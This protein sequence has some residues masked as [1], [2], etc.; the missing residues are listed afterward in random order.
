MLMRRDVQLVSASVNLMWLYAR[1]HRF[2]GDTVC[3]ALE[4]F[5]R[6]ARGGEQKYVASRAYAALGDIHEINDAP[7]AARRMYQRALRFYPLR[8]A[9][10]ELAHAHYLLGEYKFA[11]REARTVLREAPADFYAR[12]E[13][14]AAVDAH[15]ARRRPHF[16]HGDSH[17]EVAE[18]LA[19]DH[20]HAALA[21]VSRAR[22]SKAVLWRARCFGMIGDSAGLIDQWRRIAT[23]EGELQLSRTDWYYL[24]D[25]LWDCPKIWRFLLSILHRL[26]D[27]GLGIGFK[28]SPGRKDARFQLAV[29]FHL[30]RCSHDL[31]TLR[32]LASGIPDWKQVKWVLRHYERTGKMPPGGQPRLKGVI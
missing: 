11:C 23:A 7:L 4:R 21:R 1:G 19:A 2:V 6:A 30:A 32:R 16:R 13:Y 25:D 15:K 5:A 31:R 10:T 18:L 20:T 22:S 9:R 3:P 14:E 24:R 29:E 28:G 26:G 17:W 8:Y 27:L 12:E